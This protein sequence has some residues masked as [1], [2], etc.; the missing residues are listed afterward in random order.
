MKPLQGVLI[1]AEASFGPPR[2]MT[3][4]EVTLEELAAIG[5]VIAETAETRLVEIPIGAQRRLI[6]SVKPLGFDSIKAISALIDLILKVAG[7][8]GKVEI[9]ADPATFTW[10]A[11]QKKTEAEKC[12]AC[13]K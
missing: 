2:P 6:E 10:R 12:E 7:I 9:S 4:P 8:E 1:P 11:L 5:V 13:G 3:L